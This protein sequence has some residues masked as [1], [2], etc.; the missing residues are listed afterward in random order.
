MAALAGAITL[1]SAD[2]G[3][4]PH[5]G[6]G[7]PRRNLHEITAAAQVQT[8]AVRFQDAPGGGGGAHSRGWQIVRSHWR[9]FLMKRG[10]IPNRVQTGR[11]APP[12]PPQRPTNFIMSNDAFDRMLDKIMM[13]FTSE[14]PRTLA[15]INA[16]QG[17]AQAHSEVRALLPAECIEAHRAAEG[18]AAVA[19]G[20]WHKGDPAQ[21]FFHRGS[22]AVAAARDPSQDFFPPEWF[23]NLS[24]N[25]VAELVV[26]AYTSAF[27]EAFLDSAIS[28]V[29]VSSKFN[30]STATSVTGL[31]QSTSEPTLAEPQVNRRLRSEKVLRHLGLDEQGAGSP[32]GFAMSGLPKDSWEAWNSRD[33]H[34]CKPLD[35]LTKRIEKATEAQRPS[36]N[37][38]MAQSQ[39]IKRRDR[40]TDQRKYLWPMSATN[41]PSSWNTS[42]KPTQP[43]VEIAEDDEPREGQE[44]L[45]RIKN[46]QTMFPYS[47]VSHRAF[48]DSQRTPLLKEKARK[49]APLRFS[50]S[51]EKYIVRPAPRA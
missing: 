10:D 42:T 33:F 19:A 26:D 7:G 41:F 24:E 18:N 27:A 20:I 21:D 2:L 34:K 25:T 39:F 49:L 15:K 37:S 3:H 43:K 6:I 30:A 38:R 22:A 1:K 32:E 16:W 11:L 9:E 36:R 13:H 50:S 46:G 31:R 29:E 17:A 8:H 35:P 45:L 44:W 47:L 14:S 28:L 4:C 12:P 51:C 40:D 23:H 48:I 5:T